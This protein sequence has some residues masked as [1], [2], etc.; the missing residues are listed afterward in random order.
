M[1]STLRVLSILKTF[2]AK[3]T[4]ERTSP[5]ARNDNLTAILAAQLQTSMIALEAKQ[6]DIVIGQS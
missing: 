4:L 5:D 1:S 6:A 2:I 3:A